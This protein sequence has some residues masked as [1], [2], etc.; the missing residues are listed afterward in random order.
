MS[1]QTRIDRKL[2]NPPGWEV[3]L[4]AS[5]YE[6]ILALWL[7]QYQDEKLSDIQEAIKSRLYSR[8]GSYKARVKAAFAIYLNTVD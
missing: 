5:Q 7:E 2:L 8:P 6:S 4:S 1:G 3:H